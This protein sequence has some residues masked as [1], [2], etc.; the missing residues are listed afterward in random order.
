VSLDRLVLHEARRGIDALQFGLGVDRGRTGS[1]NETPLRLA[2]RVVELLVLRGQFEPF[3]R[4]RAEA[5]DHL[6]N[7]LHVLGECRDDRLVGAEFDNLAEFLQRDRLGFLHFSGAIVQR[8]FA[9]CRQQCRS[10]AGEAG[11]LGG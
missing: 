10:L 1:G 3:A 9:A 8:L 4:G 11:A 6:V 7:V 5:F 2:H